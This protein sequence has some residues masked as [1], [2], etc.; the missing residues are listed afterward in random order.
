M[1]L[2]RCITREQCHFHSS[3][4]HHP[5]SANHNPPSSQDSS[6]GCHQSLPSCARIVTDPDLAQYPLPR[7]IPPHKTVPPEFRIIVAAAEQ[8]HNQIAGPHPVQATIQL[9]HECHHIFECWVLWPHG[10]LLTFRLDVIC[11][12][13]RSHLLLH[14][15]KR[16][17]PQALHVALLHLQVRPCCKL[18]AGVVDL[19]PDTTL[20]MP[21]LSR[22]R[23]PKA[24]PK[25]RL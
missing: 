7:S 4:K 25:M 15:A 13:S 16:V 22:P 12:H 5:G 11:G 9:A 10:Q 6:A 3:W 21:W 20:V 1:L 24:D 23:G 2:Y 19:S 17:S 8:T 14:C 18:T